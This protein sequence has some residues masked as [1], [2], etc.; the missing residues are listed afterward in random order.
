MPFSCASI[1]AATVLA[2]T[3]AVAPEYAALIATCGGASSGYCSIGET[4]M[5]TA[6]A[7]TIKSEMTDERIGRSMK[8]WVNTVRRLFFR[9]VGR[10]DRARRRHDR[11]QLSWNHLLHAVNDNAAA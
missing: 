10:F 9:C 6:P 5:A 4:V 7:S 3:S 11:H 1:G 8:K 2:T